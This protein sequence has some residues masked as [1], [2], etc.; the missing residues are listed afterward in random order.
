MSKVKN[1]QELKEIVENLKQ[2]NKTIVTTNGAFDILHISHINLLKKIKSLGDVLIVLINGDSSPFFKTKGPNRP[3]VP[4]QE[5]AEMLAAL[6]SIDY[7]TIFQEDKPLNFLKE[8]KP[9]IHSKGYQGIPT[10]N[11]EEEELLESWNG[12]LEFVN[13]EG[14]HST[15]D[16]INKIKNERN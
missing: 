10:R 3:V 13:S 8:L 2:Q 1:I 4:E 11:K 5:R 14:S 12:K 16:I 6:E 15:T 9:Q 7:V